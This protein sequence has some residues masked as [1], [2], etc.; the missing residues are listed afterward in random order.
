MGTNM[1][2]P[3]DPIAD[4]KKTTTQIASQL[5]VLQKQLT[6]ADP[7]GGQL[8]QMTSQMIEALGMLEQAVE[9][10]QMMAAP[11]DVYPVQDGGDAFDAAGPQVMAMLAA[12]QQQ[13]EAGG[14]PE[15][16]GF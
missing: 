15:Q 14:I 8:V 9:N 5:G 10:P 7:T 1:G 6:A 11:Q 12:A 16:G 4:I 2:A 13:E 3:P